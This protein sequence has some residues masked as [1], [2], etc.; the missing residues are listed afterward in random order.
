MESQRLIVQP[1]YTDDH[2]GRYGGLRK[3]LTPLRDFL[4][5]AG[6]DD[7]FGPIRWNVY[8]DLPSTVVLEG[9]SDKLSRDCA[10]GVG[11]H[12]VELTCL[13]VEVIACL[14]PHGLAF[15]YRSY[16]CRSAAWS[17][18]TVDEMSGTPDK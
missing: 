1:M 15:T 10:G 9:L 7:C 5:V 12:S 18:R 3:Q 17:V 11:G 8:R 6:E 2:C 16:G 14:L 13:A 4:T